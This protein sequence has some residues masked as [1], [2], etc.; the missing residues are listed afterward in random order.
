MTKKKLSVQQ[1][2]EVYVKDLTLKVSF[3][4]ISTSENQFKGKV[5]Q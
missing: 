1:I 4:K 5:I 2:L 3:E